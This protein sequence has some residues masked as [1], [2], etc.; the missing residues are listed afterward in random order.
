MKKFKLLLPYIFLFFITLFL[1]MF[2]IRVNMDEL[3]NY[4][5]SYAIRLGEIPY[6]DF[7][8]VLTPFYPF[9]MTI[10]L[11]IN[12]SYLAYSIFYSLII[13]G[14]FYFIKKMYGDKSY[15]I[16]ILAMV[17]YE[18]LLPSYNSF[19]IVL[20]F[21]LI[22]LELSKN[23]QKDLLIG[24][25]IML[26]ILTKQSVGILFI[27][28]TILLIFLKEKPNILKRIIGL[29]I[30]SIILFIY[31]FFS[32][33]FK[34]FIDQC[35][36]GLFDFSGNASNFDIISLIIFIVVIILS[37][38]II[39]KNPKDITNY[40][41]LCS[42]SL[43]IPTFD[44]RHLILI[45]F[46]FGVLI[47][48]NYDIKGINTKK[49]Y[50]IALGIFLLYNS[51][52]IMINRGE[53][54]NKIDHLEYK[55]MEKEVLDYSYKVIDY[56]KNNDVIIYDQKLTYLDLVN[57]GNHGYNSSDKIIKELKK[58]KDKKV[59]ISI[60][61]KKEIDNNKTQV[62]REGYEYIINNYDRVATFEDY[63]IYEY[64]K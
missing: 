37:I 36:L 28:P 20:M 58:Y 61:L 38:K 14:S 9:L 42:Y 4:G 49:T 41:I 3:W 57:H 10:P 17:T 47:I 18:Y 62:D 59:M 27:I 55:F 13:T 44:A 16:I 50:Y 46:I 11:L 24:I 34:N 56:V 21:L 1:I 43:F 40:Y 6:N 8:M 35:F 53:Y 12:N 33:S 31:L 52:Y 29:I 2:C 45:L 30:P 60:N 25:L 48:N 23:K 19:V 32:H 5:F 39:K 64:R 63:Y 26:S 7:N 22:Y 51:I 54:P 15:Y